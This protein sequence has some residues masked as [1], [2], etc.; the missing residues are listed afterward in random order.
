MKAAINGVLNVSILDGWWC[1]GYA[2]ER[3]WRIGNGEEYED[4]DYQD[5][6]ES[7]ALYNVLENEVIPC[8]YDRKNGDLPGQW[9]QKMKATMKMAMEMFCSMRMVSNYA[10]RYYLPAAKRFDALLANQAEEARNLAA[11]AKRLRSLWK[12]IEI[13]PPVRKNRGPYR[14]GEKFDVTAEVSLAE[15]QP[16]E[17]DVELYYGQMK[18]LE[19]VVT[20][21]VEPMSVTEDH[22]NGHY[23]YG[24]SLTCQASGRFGFTVRVTPRGDERVKSTPRLLTWA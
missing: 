15:L 5:A 23:L 18:S 6:V 16:H 3:G 19:N 22:G 17:V 12:N 13:Q 14:V 21:N 24:C 10:N 2:A 8:F 1:E 11:H 4:Y 7:Q 9:V 20:S